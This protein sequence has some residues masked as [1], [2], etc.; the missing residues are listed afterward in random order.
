M[1]K[2]TGEL[3]LDA[4]V[5]I[6]LLS[7]LLALMIRGRRVMRPSAA[8]AWLGAVGA[9]AALAVVAIH[10][11]FLAGFPIGDSPLQLRADRLTSTLALFIAGVGALVK[12]F[13]SR[14]LAQDTE[15][16]R[17]AAG[18][19]LVVASM[20]I[21]ATASNIVLLAIGWAAAGISFA[22]VLGY[23]RDLPGVS[24]GAKMA[25]LHFIA[26]D[27]ALGVAV[28]IVVAKVGN[29]RLGGGPA[30]AREAGL[31]GW[32][33]IPV[34]A[35]ITLA[36]LTR[37]AQ[38]PMGRWLPASIAAPTPVSALLHAGVVNGG[39]ILL[40][41]TAGLAQSN[42]WAAGAALLIAVVTAA[43]ATRLM[44]HRADVKGELAYSTIAQM[45]FMT[46]EASV[47]AYL[48][49][50]VHLMSHGAFKAS[51]F[52]SSG[53][54]VRRGRNA[55][56]RHRESSAAAKIAAATAAGGAALVATLLVGSGA[57]SRAGDVLAAFA[58]ATAASASWS[59]T[60]CLPGSLWAAL[61]G[62]GVLI[63]SSF[64][65]GGSV[66]LLGQWMAPAV[67]LP[68]PGVLAPIWL[69]ALAGASAVVA[70]A[71]RSRRLRSGLTAWS[72]DAATSPATR[73]RAPAFLFNLRGGVVEQGLELE[74][75]D[76]A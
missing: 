10:G 17:F 4:A 3:G 72:I 57:T 23:R 29:L 13:S 52:L 27:A 40:V 46:A 42:S 59:F 61:A 20:T 60:R 35:L 36:A 71:G 9:F 7:A 8:L 64:A 16:W 51:L 62:V 34:A 41:R 48:A 25:L 19:D 14:Y 49:T 12:G 39:G 11:S 67:P 54:R 76:A 50:L 31:L 22:A 75:G 28:A 37:S 24:R 30:L 6:P 68:A 69:L 21:V 38:G 56:R 45:A 1:L 44:R 74:E 18:A 73:D 58:V 47:G 26:G 2:I 15:A 65:Y 70:L 66:A 53:S 43:M 32:A 55:T 63:T 5:A 33:A